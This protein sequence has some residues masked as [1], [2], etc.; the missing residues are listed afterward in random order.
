M[1]CGLVT[2]G[3]MSYILQFPGRQSPDSDA[4]RQHRQPP[5]RVPPAAAADPRLRPGQDGAAGGQT[6]RSVGDG[7]AVHSRIRSSYENGRVEAHVKFDGRQTHL[8]P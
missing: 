4:R 1:S 6:A 7:S 3:L 5:G 2:D 8:T